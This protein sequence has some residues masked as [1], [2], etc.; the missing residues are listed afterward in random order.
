MQSSWLLQQQIIATI[1]SGLQ[2]SNGNVQGEECTLHVVEKTMME[3]GPMMEEV[4]EGWRSRSNE[5]H[6]LHDSTVIWG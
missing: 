5:L 4:H 3:F 2:A 1:T 6:Y